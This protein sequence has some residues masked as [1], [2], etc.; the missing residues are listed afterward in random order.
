M[1]KIELTKYEKK[2]I[3]LCKGKH[4]YK[5]DGTI[6]TLIKKYYKSVYLLDPDEYYQDCLRCMFTKMFN[7]YMKIRDWGGTENA[8]VLDVFY[9]SFQKGIARDQELPIERAI[10]ELYGRIQCTTV[11]EKDASGKYRWRFDIY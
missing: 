5:G 9:A 6:L 3:R 11:R 2:L 10:A 7:T 8:D 1:K 4:P